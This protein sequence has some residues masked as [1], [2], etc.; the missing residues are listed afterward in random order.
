MNRFNVTSVTR[1]KECALTE[2]SKASKILYFT[3]NLNGEAE[4][5]SIN[6][7]AVGSVKKLKWVIDFSD[8]AIK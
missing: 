4:T 7:R 5:I 1:D 6:L 3:V 8:L 2:G